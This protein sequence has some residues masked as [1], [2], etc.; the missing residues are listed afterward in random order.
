M[1]SSVLSL[2]RRRVAKTSEMLLQRMV[3]LT[4]SQ[5]AM[6]GSDSP[7]AH[8][9]DDDT[10]DGNDRE[11]EEEEEE[12]EVETN[13]LVSYSWSNLFSR[14]RRKDLMQKRRLKFP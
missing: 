2:I 10:D 4:R 5:M 7:A 1:I 13:D 9:D 8:P 11:E 14:K 3:P 6:A 12:S